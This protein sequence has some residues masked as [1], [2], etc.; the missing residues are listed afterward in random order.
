MDTW[1]LDL[2]NRAVRAGIIK[3][4]QWQDRLDEPVPLWVVLELT[5]KLNEL[6]DPPHKPYD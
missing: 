3:D 4:P 5:M 6:L 1:K 2:F